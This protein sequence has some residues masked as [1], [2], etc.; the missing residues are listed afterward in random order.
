MPCTTQHASKIP[1]QTPKSAKR[2]VAAVF[3]EYNKGRRTGTARTTW[4]DILSEQVELAQ[5]A[6]VSTRI[7]GCDEKEY[8]AN[9]GLVLG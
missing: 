4:L 7:D 6:D 2:T 5:D 1:S 3:L 8:N 9:D